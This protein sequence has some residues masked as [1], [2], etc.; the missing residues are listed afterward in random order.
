[1]SDSP[2]YLAWI[3]EREIGLAAWMC[4]YLPKKGKSLPHGLI[5]GNELGRLKIVIGRWPTTGPEA[6]T[7]WKLLR[8]M[9]E[10]WTQ[11]KIRDKRKKDKQKACSFVLSTDAQKNLQ[12][13]I[14]LNHHDTAAACLEW[15]LQNSSAQRNLADK[16]RKDTQQR[17][18]EE[19]RGKQ[20]K[21]DI[22]GH[23]LGNTLTELAIFTI[24][25]HEAKKTCQELSKPREDEVN[26]ILKTVK[27]NAIARTSN[28]TNLSAKHIA[29]LIKQQTAE[30]ISA[31]I[32]NILPT[33]FASLSTTD[34]EPSEASKTQLINTTI[35]EIKTENINPDQH[36]Q[37]LPHCKP[38]G[39]QE[40]KNP[41]QDTP[42]A[43]Q[44]RTP[45]K[46]QIKKTRLLPR[47]EI[48]Q[49]KFDDFTGLP[50][51]DDDKNSEKSADDESST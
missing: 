28:L 51:L 7:T 25:L 37:K 9:N 10:A 3:N 49:G 32:E 6:D 15:L 43:L 30:Q 4:S 50:T 5:K 45:M 47:L 40:I 13:L 44:T 35:Q 24:G 46:L 18:E 11:Q 26:K 21:I 48:P 20:S 38:I 39:I 42:A 34:I 27:S 16:E 31:C 22:L 14:K 29:G 41:I 1:M 12:R 33:I 2:H 19:L 17:H 8:Q 23:L 36:Q